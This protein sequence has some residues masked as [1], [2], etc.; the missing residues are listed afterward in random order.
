MNNTFDK[1]K[2][3]PFILIFLVI[4]F[5][6]FLYEAT[7]GLL[8]LVEDTWSDICLEVWCMWNGVDVEDIE[9]DLEDDDNEG[10]KK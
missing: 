6:I 8:D 10:D 4:A 3:I 9:V 5:F 2:T 7:I 1:I